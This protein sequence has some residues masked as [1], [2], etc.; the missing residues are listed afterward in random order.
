MPVI[1]TRDDIFIEIPEGTDPNDPGVVRMVQEE[2]ARRR[3]ATPEFQEKVR[4]EEA[5]GR[6]RFAAEEASRPGHER[7]LTNIGA[8]AEKV[9]QALSFAPK[10]QVE[11]AAKYRQSA[12]ETLPG[13]SVVQAAAEALPTLVVPAGAVG[14]VAARVLPAAVGRMLATRTGS[15][16]NIGATGAAL[17]ALTTPGDAQDRAIGGALSAAGGALPATVA[18]AVQGGRRMA[19]NYGGQLATGER[20]LRGLEQESPQRVD[21]LLARL[22]GPNPHALAGVER[23]TAAQLTG[24]P[25]LRELEVG[26]RGRQAAAF[27]A[28][29]E[30]AAQG[31]ANVL[32]RIAGTPEDLA[33]AEAQR[34]AATAPM[35]DA[36][37]GA[38]EQFHGQGFER[39]LLN[40]LQDLAS[41]EM[42]PNANV[43]TMVRYVMGELQQGVTPAQLY[44]VRKVLTTNVPAGDLGAAIRQ[45]GNARM[46]MVAAIDEA[47]NIASAGQWGQYM[48][49]FQTLSQP[50][51][52]MR[53]GQ[54]I[55]RDFGSSANTTLEGDPV[56]TASRL[57]KA[58]QAR[59]EKQFGQQR[60]SRITP[61]ERVQL[62]AVA[63]SAEASTRARMSQGLEGSRTAGN[64]AAGDN[65][66]M[67]AQGI[68]HLVGGGVPGAVI[69]TALPKWM[70]GRDER[71]LAQLLQDPELLALMIQRARDARSTMRAVGEAGGRFGRGAAVAD[72][73]LGG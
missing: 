44:T 38:A 36:A 16:A 32:N 6:A 70:R 37:L 19:T 31:R 17:G 24:D 69:S 53:A 47:L 60:L 11:E 61:F 41:G 42:R 40:V 64:I 58:I 68:G 35:R 63:D 39:P 14:N 5:V 55:Q 9:G 46:Q 29:D 50:V 10:E 62:E 26:A 12:A 45:S 56:L 73:Y 57:R 22:R 28:G 43:Q 34:Q 27:A 59:G 7:L 23:P 66:S 4:R 8:A 30:A 54:Q 21:E 18:A 49:R 52:S 67:V 20:F 25:V 3:Q 48:Q 51:T 33:R 2:R 71:I 72:D 1:Q 13:G 65:M 15:I